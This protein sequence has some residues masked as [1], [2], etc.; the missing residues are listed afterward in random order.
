[1]AGARGD[2][3]QLR[4]LLGRLEVVLPGQVTPSLRA[5]RARF[6][7]YLPEADADAEFRT[8]ER[9]FAE[10]ELPFFLAITRLEAAGRLLAADRESDAE[11][12]VAAAAQA[13]E[14][15]RATPWLDRVERLSPGATRSSGAE[16]EPALPA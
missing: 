12:L 16:S 9:V 4:T 15:L 14:H 5:F 1:V 3:E 13:F 8:A 6:R 10:L 7:A 2:L 11:P